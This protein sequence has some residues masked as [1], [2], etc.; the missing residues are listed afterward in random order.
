M[1]LN[2]GQQHDKE[3]PSS[4]KSPETNGGPM[5]SFGSVPESGLQGYLYELGSLLVAASSQKINLLDVD[6][7]LGLMSAMSH[8]RVW[9]GYFDRGLWDFVYH[10]EDTMCLC[11]VYLNVYSVP[12]GEHYVSL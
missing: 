8:S 7:E 12:Q 3:L 5:G 9:N 4:F 2:E 6:S 1:G 10:I 11:R